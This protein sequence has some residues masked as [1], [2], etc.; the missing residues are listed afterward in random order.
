MNLCFLLYVLYAPA[1]RDYPDLLMALMAL[2]IARKQNGTFFGPKK[3]SV[4]LREG[5]CLLLVECVLLIA[6]FGFFLRSTS[7]RGFKKI[8]KE[9][10]ALPAEFSR[11]TRAEECCGDDQQ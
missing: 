8:A 5:C 11:T 10:D 2:L 9:N 1:T 4:G 3:R 7:A 6:P